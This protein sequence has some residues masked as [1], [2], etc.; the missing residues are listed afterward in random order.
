MERI[1]N[2]IKG[3]CIALYKAGSC[4]VPF[5]T[6]ERDIEY[7][8]ICSSD[9][10]RFTCLD[11]LFPPQIEIEVP[12]INEN[13][14]EEIIKSVVQEEPLVPLK[15]RF[16]KERNPRC[17][18]WSYQYHYAYIGE[19]Y[20]QDIPEYDYNILDHKKDYID[21]LIEFY[22]QAH[23]K[24]DKQWYHILIG[25]Y[26]LENNSYELTQ[27][28]QHEVQ[29]AHDN[30]ISDATYNWALSKLKNYIDNYDLIG[31]SEAEL[32]IVELKKHLADTDYQAIKF[33]EG[34][35]S[36]EDYAPVKAQRQQ[37]RAR[38]NELEAELE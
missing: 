35:L 26:I 37:W 5:L 11:I 34:E 9:E 17:E 24:N 29:L 22:Y 6:K 28:Q 27:T 18:I 15:T 12:I 30:K 25:L 32:E 13:G 3:H 14:E 33:A 4:A 23:R 2:Y 31:L 10:D 38:I 19:H 16:I 8:L 1:Y 21:K 20:G 7:A 36:A